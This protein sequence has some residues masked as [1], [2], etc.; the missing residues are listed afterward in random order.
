MRAESEAVHEGTQKAATCGLHAVNHALR[1]LGMVLTWE[2]FDRR[3]KPDERSPSGDWD[4]GALHRN[5]EAAG[6]LLMPVDSADLTTL[7]RWNPEQATLTLWSQDTL[8]C[9]MHVPGH[10]VAL[11]RPD[12]PQTMDA[13]AL[14]CDSMHKKR[15]KVVQ[16]GDP[17]SICFLLTSLLILF[18]SFSIHFLLIFYSFSTPF[19]SFPTP[20]WGDEKSWKII[21]NRVFSNRL[22]AGHYKGMLKIMGNRVFVKF[23]NIRAVFKN[24]KKMQKNAKF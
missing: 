16:T 1:P 10:W 6:A 19:Y 5:V 4:I 23:P 14:L 12:I 8:G 3:S 11:S 17:C 13:A 21:G 15:R 24:C 20:L 18:H 7:T 9:V 22:I 2:D